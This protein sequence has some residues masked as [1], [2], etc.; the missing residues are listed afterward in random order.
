MYSIY[1]APVPVITSV[2]AVTSYEWDFGDG[3]PAVFGPNPTH[4]Y[5]L[6]GTYTVR[7]IITT[8]TGCRDTLIIP[9]AVRT[10]SKPTADFSA[11]PIPVCATEQVQFTDLSTPATVDEWLWDF[12]DGATAAIQN[13]LHSY[14]DTGYFTVR[15]IA[16]NNGCPDTVLQ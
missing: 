12:G 2:D 3:S 14:N 15:L 8:S 1:I 7:L 6:Q 10:G 11:V 4:T 5:P 13:P 9:S 16:T